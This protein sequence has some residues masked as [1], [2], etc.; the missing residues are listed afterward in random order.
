MTLLAK[1]EGGESHNSYKAFY[2]QPISVRLGIL[3]GITVIMFGVLWYFFLSQKVNELINAIS[4]LKKAEAR[5]NEYEAMAKELPK[6][7]MEFR[8]LN[9]EFEEAMSK[10]SQKKDIHSLIDSVSAA[11]SAS[12]LESVTFVPKPLV[13]KGIYT[14]IPIEMR[15]YGTYYDIAMF[16]DIVSKLPG[17][18]NIRD[19]NLSRDTEKSFDDKI[20]LNA[21]FTAVAFRLITSS[22]K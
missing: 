22:S 12:S 18:V 15:V 21:S 4:E 3:L 11:I 2:R 8:N 19:L 10:L 7:E 1:K 20:V 14:E 9:E 13:K 6:F 17:I 16:F 5:L